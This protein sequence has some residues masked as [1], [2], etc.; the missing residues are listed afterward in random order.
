MKQLDIG[1]HALMICFVWSARHSF[2]NFNLTSV[3][4]LQASGATET[5]WAELSPGFLYLE[6]MCRMLEKL[7]QLKMGH[8]GL[9]TEI[10]QLRNQQNHRRQ[11]STQVG[12]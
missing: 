4:P 5:G 7:A 8:H 6:Q 3:L 11:H 9:Q 12:G 2:H 1:K 10:E